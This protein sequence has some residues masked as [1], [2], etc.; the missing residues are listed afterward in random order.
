MIHKVDTF[1]LYVLGELPGAGRLPSCLTQWMMK[2]QEVCEGDDGTVE[3]PNS[4]HIGTS[5]FV[6]YRVVALSSGVKM[7]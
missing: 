2:S 4:G 6:L 5:H 7:Y 3:P 1:C